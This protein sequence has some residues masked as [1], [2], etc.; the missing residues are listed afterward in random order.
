MKN[1]AQNFQRVQILDGAGGDVLAWESKGWMWQQVLHLTFTVDN[2]A[3]ESNSADVELYI[4][5]SVGNVLF[6]TEAAG[7][8]GPASIGIGTYAVNLPSSDTI[9]TRPASSGAQHFTRALPDLTF[10]T[11]ISVNIVLSNNA[12]IGGNVAIGDVIATLHGQRIGDPA[13]S[14][15]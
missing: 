9:T 5:D 11:D 1:A 7:V 8:V 4:A 3:A 10:N 15:G 12:D 14:S 13:Q 6:A 2:S